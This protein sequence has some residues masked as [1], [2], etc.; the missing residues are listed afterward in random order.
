[1]LLLPSPSR[2]LPAPPPCS[3]A[4]TCYKF[5]AA[6]TPL[7]TPSFVSVIV[8]LSISSTVAYVLTAS[9]A[10]VVCVLRSEAE[11]VSRRGLPA[12]L[13]NKNYICCLQCLLRLL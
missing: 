8:L 11:H 10:P 4:P 2:L 3:F 6:L 7:P 1:M 5:T 9:S 13:L 12:L